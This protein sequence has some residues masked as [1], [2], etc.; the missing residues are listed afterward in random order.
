[1]PRLGALVVG[2]VPA[3]RGPGSGLLSLVKLPSLCS[4]QAKR[5]LGSRLLR[6]RDF[7]RVKLRSLN[8]V[9]V[10]ET[11][12]MVPLRSSGYPQARPIGLRVEA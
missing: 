7:S 11:N 3:A 4:L 1:M 12:P 9:E 5:D 8:C 10:K 2:F 6:S